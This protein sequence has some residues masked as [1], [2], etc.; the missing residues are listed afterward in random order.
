MTNSDLN[1]SEVGNID[2]SIVIVNYNVKDYLLQCLKSIYAHK[3][4]LIIQTIVVDNASTDNSVAELRGLFPNVVWVALDENVGFGR[5]NNVGLELCRG[6][7]TLYLN[8]DTVLGQDTLDRMKIYL[9]QNP[10]VGL[11]GC[12]VLNADGTFQIACRRGFPTPWASF[13]KLFGLQALWP[14]SKLFAGYNLTYLPINATYNVDALIGAFM[15]GPT[16]LLVN[17]GGF[18]PDF[19]MYGEDLDLCKRVQLAG[20]R[21]VYN[22]STSIVHYKGES[23]K[24]SAINENKVF[25][26]AME[27]FAHKH[28]GSSR[29]FLLFLRTG[30]RTRGLIEKLLSKKSDIGL[31]FLDLVLINIALLCATTLKFDSPFGFPAYAYPLVFVVISLVAGFSLISVGEYV[32]Y[33]PTIRRSSVAMLLLFFFLSSCTYFFKEYAFSRGVLLM[34][35]GFS[36]FL[37]ALARGLVVL[38]DTTKGPQKDRRIVFIGLNQHTQQIMQA[39][40]TAKHRH[41]TIVGVVAVDKYELDTFSGIP[42]LG[43]TEYL[44]RILS[45]AQADEVVLTDQNVGH[46]KA[47]EL[48]MQCASLHVRF[49]LASD[50]DDV[51]TARIINDVAD[52]EPTVATS[53]LVFFR[54]RVVKRSIDLLVAIFVLPFKAIAVFLSR[55]EREVGIRVWIEVA[56]GERSLIGLYPDNRSRTT[57][58]PGITGLAHISNPSALSQ[59]AIAQLNDFYVDRYSLALDIEIL[60]KHFLNKNRG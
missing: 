47:M 49:H 3:T 31:L 10:D 48:M 2:V 26:L 25:Y 24:R 43:T 7:Y 15:M 23:T 30:I 45:S 4:N 28:F 9:D 20:R 5:G 32:E 38:Y 12:K 37:L 59:Q 46:N 33:K 8:P 35:I 52:V 13:C 29:M 36:T 53:P 22:H 18:D 54:N 1:M 34:T 11:A 16:D 41:A 50:Y 14:S 19:F 6:K 57:G 55:D 44:A 40:Q 51:V 27:L 60:L 17:L 42:V 56:R 21:V 58:K 39:L